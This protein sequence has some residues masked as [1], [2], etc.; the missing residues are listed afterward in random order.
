MDQVKQNSKAECEANFKKFNSA[1]VET[2]ASCIAK[3][4]PCPQGAGAVSDAIEQK[5]ADKEC[6][7]SCEWVNDVLAINAALQKKGQCGEKDPP[8]KETCDQIIASAG[9]WSGFH[10]ANKCTNVPDKNEEDKGKDSTTDDN[11]SKTDSA[12][13]VTAM[14]SSIA[15]TALLI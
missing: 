5:I 7:D 3:I 2:A 10:E 13:T 11:A 12:F 4:G 1:D 6:T 15:A 9:T 8:N 14:A